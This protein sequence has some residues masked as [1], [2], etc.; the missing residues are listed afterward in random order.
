MEKEEAL[1]QLSRFISGQ[2]WAALATVD[3]KG[4]PQASM[5]A[6]VPETGFGGLLLHLSQ[7]AAHTRHALETPWAAL[8][9]TEPDGGEGDPQTLVRAS[10]A[11]PIRPIAR[12]SESYQEAKQHYLAR[13][14]DA[15]QRFGFGDF[16]LLRLQ[17]QSVRFVAGFGRA[18]S[19]SGTELADLDRAF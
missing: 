4:H 5:V 10:V 7:L 3:E 16:M 11:G 19:F 2:R 18:Y 17:P 8:V 15:E 12:E 14:P 1:Q 13:L 9:I 6:Y